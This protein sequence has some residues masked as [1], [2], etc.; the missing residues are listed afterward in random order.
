MLETTDISNKEQLVV[1]ILWVDKSLQ[2]HEE[3]IGLLILKVVAYINSVWFL[4]M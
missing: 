2:P 1:C 3:L 4:G